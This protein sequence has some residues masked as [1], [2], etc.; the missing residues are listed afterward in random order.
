MKPRL[1]THKKWS[2]EMIE[3]TIF[4]SS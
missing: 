4:D 1:Y 3:K 2:F